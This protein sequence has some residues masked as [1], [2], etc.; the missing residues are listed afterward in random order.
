ML[1]FS[2]AQE[3]AVTFFGARFIQS[4]EDRYPGMYLGMYLDKLIIYFSWGRG[5]C[6]QVE[7]GE[8]P[9]LLRTIRVRGVFLRDFA[10]D[11]MKYY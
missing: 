9:A 8:K 4:D 6:Q 3:F 2:Y 5:Q 11:F 1:S 10:I 7:P